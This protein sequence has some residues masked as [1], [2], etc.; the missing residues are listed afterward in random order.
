MTVDAALKNALD[1][2]GFPVEKSV[3]M[4]K[5]KTYFTF[6][7]ATYGNNFADDAPQNETYLVQVHFFAP[8]GGNI[9][10]QVKNVKKALF[11][12]DFTWAET[13]D[14]TD[15]NG[16]H[17]VFECETTKGTFENGET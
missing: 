8:L 1:G 3:Y 11:N 15:E 17:I 9:L 12:N 4:G 2:F 7:Y 14:A 16:R 5:E 6:N 13:T 10:K